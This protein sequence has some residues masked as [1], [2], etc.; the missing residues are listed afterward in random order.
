MVSIYSLE[1]ASMRSIPSIAFSDFCSPHF[2]PVQS[3]SVQF[4]MVSIYAL[5]KVRMRSTS[6]L[7][8]LTWVNILI[9]F[10][11]SPAQFKIASNNALRKA[12]Y[13]LH[14]VWFNTITITTTCLIQVT[15]Y[16]LHICCPTLKKRQR[17]K[18]RTP[19]KWH[20]NSGVLQNDTQTRTSFKM[21]YKHKFPSKWHTNTNVLQND[22]Q[23]RMSFKMT[24]IHERPS[25]LHT[26]TNFLQNDT[27]TRTSSPR[28]AFVKPLK[29][30]KTHRS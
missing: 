23:T 11:F 13:V 27:Q 8:N 26:N 9:F 29:R 25:K 17:N 22:I 10:R 21:T 4:K 18:T 1:K 15:G 30:R 19:S 3:C 24:Y 5:G 28:T 14:P 16:R 6:Y 20:A 7:R 12:P 2:P